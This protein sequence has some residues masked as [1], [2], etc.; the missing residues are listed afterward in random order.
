MTN[1]LLAIALAFATMPLTFAATQTKPPA[2]S[3]TPSTAATTKVK[4][5]KKT[6]KKSTKPASTSTASPAA[7]TKK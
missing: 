7:M 1:R 2:G 3:T 4:K 6:H 5:H